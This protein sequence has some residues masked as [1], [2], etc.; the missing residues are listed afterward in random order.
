MFTPFFRI[1]VVIIAATLAYTIPALLQRSPAVS[2]PMFV[3][4]IFPGLSV[5]NRIL[6][7]VIPPKYERRDSP[8]ISLLGK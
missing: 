1:A 6:T 3:V 7:T 2:W 8:F 4:F 5:A